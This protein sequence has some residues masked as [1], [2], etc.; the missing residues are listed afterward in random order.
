MNIKS[1]IISDICV[2][3]NNFHNSFVAQLNNFYKL[4]FLIGHK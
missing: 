2:I 4:K 1:E 3:N